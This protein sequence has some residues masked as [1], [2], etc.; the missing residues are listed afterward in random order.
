VV[1]DNG[2]FTQCESRNINGLSFL[3]SLSGCPSFTINGD[4]LY[5]ILACLRLT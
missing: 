5:S 2:Q 4:F 1:K 3:M